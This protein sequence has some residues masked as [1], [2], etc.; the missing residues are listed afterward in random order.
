MSFGIHIHGARL[1]GLIAGVAVII[2]ILLCAVCVVCRRRRRKRISKKVAHQGGTPKV[3]ESIPRISEDSHQGG[4][5]SSV[6]GQ[7]LKTVS[8]AELE[9]ATKG[10][11][12]VLGRGAF[13]VVHKGTLED[14]AEVAIKQLIDTNHGVNDFEAEVKTLGRVNHTNLVTL[15]GFTLHRNWKFLIYE[16]VEKGSLDQWIFAKDIANGDSVLPWKAKVDI[17]RG[18]AR[19]LAYL[20]TELQRGKAIIHLDIKPQNTQCT[21]AGGLRIGQAGREDGSSNV[22]CRR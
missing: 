7:G 1:Y 22:C 21:Q 19:G 18:T 3:K 12:Q 5:P 13:G 15:L 2:I 8:Y 9:K 16:F 10:F 20:H 14:G 17:L 6:T 11:S 4:P